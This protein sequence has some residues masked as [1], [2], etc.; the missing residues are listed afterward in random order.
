MEELLIETIKSYNQYISNIP[1]GAENIATFLREDN[2]KEAVHEIKY[3]SEG[4]TWLM[5]IKSIFARVGIDTELKIEEILEF[6]EEINNGLL[7]ED[8]VLVADMFEYEIAPFFA[9][10]KQISEVI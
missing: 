8:F 9:D 10:V 2:I 6:L 4:I 3:F 7:K 5:E 1:T